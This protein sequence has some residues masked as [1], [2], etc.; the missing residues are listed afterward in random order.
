MKLNY[1]NVSAIGNT[2]GG[3]VILEHEGKY[4]WLIEDYNTNF[5]NLDE[6]IEISK[7]LYLEI[8]KYNS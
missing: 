2:Y 4:Y 8:K 1:E 5:N 7:E 6:Y 3:L